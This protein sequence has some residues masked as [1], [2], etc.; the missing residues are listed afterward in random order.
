VAL[1]DRRVGAQTVEIFL[2]FYVI[3]PGTLGSLD[4]HIQGV[5]VVGPKPLIEFDK[6]FTFHR[7][8]SVRSDKKSPIFWEK[9]RALLRTGRSSVTSVRHLFEYGIIV[10]QIRRFVKFRASVIQQR[11]QVVIDQP[12][13]GLKKG[14]GASKRA[15]LRPG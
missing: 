12:L 9:N 15:I 11:F 3:N 10:H 5:I 7:F 13:A 1:V 6:L 8:S 2:A 14:V 4:N